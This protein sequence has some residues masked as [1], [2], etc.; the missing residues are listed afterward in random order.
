MK[1]QDRL[2]RYELVTKPG[3]EDVHL[4]IF[5]AAE[6]FFAKELE[7]DHKDF[8]R[9]FNVLFF[10]DH[11]LQLPSCNMDHTISYFTPAGNKRFRKGVRKLINLYLELSDV[12]VKTVIK[13]ITEID[14]DI[15]LY[16]DKYQVILYRG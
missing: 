9:V 1:D 14:P 11:R 10:L 7:D 8:D 5:S 15:I 4:G 2:Y 12:H 6:V 16:R 3:Y 13:D